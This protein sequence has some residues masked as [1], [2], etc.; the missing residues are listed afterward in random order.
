VDRLAAGRFV[1]PGRSQPA[2]GAEP[3]PFSRQQI[4]ERSRADSLAVRGYRFPP[5]SVGFSGDTHMDWEFLRYMPY[6]TST[7][8]NAGYT[9]GVTISADITEASGARSCT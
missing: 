9:C 2:L 6:F 8:S 5:V 4:E 3:L 7:A 1:R